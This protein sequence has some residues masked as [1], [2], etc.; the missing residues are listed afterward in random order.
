MLEQSE[1]PPVKPELV[2][3]HWVRQARLSVGPLVIGVV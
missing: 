2:T 3:S 1:D